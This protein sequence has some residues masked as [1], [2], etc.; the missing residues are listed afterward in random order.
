MATSAPGRGHAGC[1]AEHG[2]RIGHVADRRVADHG[3][4]GCIGQVESLNIAGLELGPLR[5]VVAGSQAHGG[6]KQHR[7]LVHADH[8][9]AEISAAGQCPRHD[10]GA[11]A[12]IQNGRLRPQA[13]PGQVIV[14]PLGESGVL[15]PEL[16][17][18]NEALNCGLV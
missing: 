14:T 5:D 17:A 10:A 4:K 16:Q 7:A 12:E 1:L 8:G 2:Q 3:V 11:A 18:V 9:A 13:K 15:A 6:L